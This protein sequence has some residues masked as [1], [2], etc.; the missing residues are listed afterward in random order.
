MLMIIYETQVI[1]VD[2]ITLQRAIHFS[3][4][5]HTSLSVAPVSAS[6]PS[7]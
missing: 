3:E 5:V 7:M 1:F 2:Q 4:R 6:K